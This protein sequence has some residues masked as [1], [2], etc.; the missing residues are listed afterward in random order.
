MWDPQHAGKSLV[1]AMAV[2]QGDATSDDKAMMGVE[3][4]LVVL[5]FATVVLR[6]Y[7]RLGIKRKLALDDILII[8]AVIC[9]LARTVISCLSAGHTFGFDRDGPDAKAQV[10]FYRYIFERRIAYILAI[11]FTRLSILTYYLR[12]FPPQIAT[13][14][15]LT[16]LLIVLALAHSIGVLTVLSVLCRTIDCLWTSKWLDF[17]EGQCFSSP[18]YSYTAAIGDAI[19]DTL[20]FALPIP[21]VWRLSKLRARQRV[22]LV[23]VFGLGFL[24]CVVALCEIPFIQRRVDNNSYF[25]G[26][27]NLL[28]AIQICLAIIAASLP[29][30]RGLIARSFPNFSPLHHRNLN[31]R[32][33]GAGGVERDAE[34]GERGQAGIEQMGVFERQRALRKPDWLRESLP[35][36]LM[37]TNVETTETRA[38]IS[39][40]VSRDN[41]ALPRRPSIAVVNALSEALSRDIVE[42]PKRLSS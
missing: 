6:V 3:I 33:G 19:V 30:L 42:L 24:V 28:I 36:S 35:D 12:I 7:S 16:I 38:P 8:C 32:R 27:I 23:V 9:A 25:G 17:N 22:G 5:A 39:R 13:L 20:I 37:G 10:P 4:P 2:A 31:T 15:I 18:I 21:Y 26:S 14:R 1:E 29:D 34:Q 40:A 41:L 11:V